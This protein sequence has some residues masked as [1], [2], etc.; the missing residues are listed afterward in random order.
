[1]AVIEVALVRGVDLTDR[2]FVFPRTR[3]ASY[4]EEL[5]R[6]GAGSF[7]ILATDPALLENPRYIDDGLTVR[8]SVDG[9]I[10]GHFVIRTRQVE[11]I[12]EGE[13]A[14]QWITVSGP[15]LK[16]SY[17]DSVVLPELYRAVPTRDFNFASSQF[18]PPGQ[19]WPMARYAGGTLD[20]SR[21]GGSPGVAGWSDRPGDW[22][23]GA[24][25]AWI[26]DRENSYSSGITAP[27]GWCFFRQSFTITRAMTVRVMFSSD[28]YGVVFLDGQVVASNETWLGWQKIH[29]ADV[30]LASGTHQFAAKVNNNG[31]VIAG[32]IV[33]VCEL[34]PGATTV[35][36]SKSVMWSS[37]TV[38]CLSYSADEPGY[39]IGRML[40]ELNVEAGF[41]NAH[42]F[43]LMFDGTV[44]TYGAP[45]AGRYAMSLPVGAKLTEVLDYVTDGGYAEHWFDYRG[46]LCM[47]PV[48]GQD[49]SGQV[50]FVEGH[51]TLKAAVDASAAIVNTLWVKKDAGV[52]KYTGP[53]FSLY[54]YGVREGYLSAGSRTNAELDADVAQLFQKQA[55]PQTSPT[56]DIYPQGGDVPWVDFGVG[57]WVTAPGDFPGEGNRRRRVMSVA[58]KENE[59]GAVDYS[60]EIDTITEDAQERTDRRLTRLKNTLD[61][62]GTNELTYYDRPNS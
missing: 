34:V 49:R 4:L 43:S 54:T 47:A 40:T 37:D 32:L 62:T 45:W 35:D 7:K 50:F 26:W 12:S 55:F 2:Y 60:I 61:S 8:V 10:A 24:P 3:E 11:V 51:N 46:R 57:D 42:N 14:G 16:G 36:Y 58:V 41:R 48:R 17:D 33:N 52:V 1:M 13:F 56:L 38:Q 53:A 5:G 21:P 6:D 15:G 31:A 39:S 29:T 27:V 18:L 25:G 44:D 20:G 9:A 59:S 19:S 23:A 30:T 28:D 22:P